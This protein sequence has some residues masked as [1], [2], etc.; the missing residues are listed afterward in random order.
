VSGRRAR[1]ERLS[2]EELL[3]LR[4]K[5]LRLS[6]RGTILEECVRQINRELRARSIRFRPHFWLSNEFFSP[7]GVPGIALPFYLA[8]PRLAR[9]ERSQML[10]IEGGTP[11]WCLKI[12]RHE[13]GHAIDT[14]YRLRRRKHWREV[15]GKASSR[16]PKYYTATP[17]SKSYVLHLDSWYAQSHPLEDFAETFAVWLTPGT[18]WR[19]RYRDWPALYKIAYVDDLMR[20]I[21]RTPPPV[22]SKARVDPLPKMKKTL[23]QHYKEKR[24]HY[25]EEFPDVYDRDL[26]RLFSEATG[27]RS[28]RTAVSF[29]RRHRSTIRRYV[30]LYTGQHA[31]TIDMLLGEMISRCRKLKLRAIR[32]ER[33]L[34]LEAMLLVTVQ[35]MNF[36]HTG[37]HLIPL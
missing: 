5:D 7:D 12:L 19:R 6:I 27:R 14:A 29:L 26:K 28:G 15:F 17:Q 9:L 2:D 18:N 4:F 36:L 11:E 25:G 34:R 37:R 35:M 32:P 13:V 10:E 33:E 8:H 23:R 24:R 3:G 31:Y 22:T 21:A 20:E 30:A 1:W 16:Y